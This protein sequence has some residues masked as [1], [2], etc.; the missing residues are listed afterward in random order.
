MEGWAPV[1]GMRTRQSLA[2]G[3][4]GPGLTP[5][6][7][8]AHP[9]DSSRMPPCREG[10]RRLRLAP[11]Q[12]VRP[13]LC[14]IIWLLKFPLVPTLPFNPSGVGDNLPGPMTE[15]AAGAAAPPQ[16]LRQV[17]P[18]STCARAHRAV[19]RWRPR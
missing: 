15:A 12:P 4:P 7:I 1:G 2:A 13:A 9:A 19:T 8:P 3:P 11:V 14:V 10:A 5:T 16:L 6:Q 17:P 18:A